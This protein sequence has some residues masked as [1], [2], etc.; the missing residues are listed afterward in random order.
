MTIFGNPSQEKYLSKFVR[1]FVDEQ[2]GLECASC[3][4]T[5]SDTNISIFSDGNMSI[6]EWKDM[7]DELIDSLNRHGYGEWE[8]L[9]CWTKGCHLML[10]Q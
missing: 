1:E 5:F 3:C 7:V 10:V 2:I 4:T 6:D 9:G 8:L